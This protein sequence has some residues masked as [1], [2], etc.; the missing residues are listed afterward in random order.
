VVV[1]DEDAVVVAER[2]VVVRVV[3]VVRA[4]DAGEDEE[5]VVAVVD[6]VRTGEKT[7]TANPNRG[8]LR[9]RHAASCIV[10]RVRRCMFYNGGKGMVVYGG[11]GCVG[12][13]PRPTFIVK[14]VYDE[15]MD[16]RLVIFNCLTTNLVFVAIQSRQQPCCS[17]II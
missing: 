1:V 8:L 16:A 7:A 12:H 11:G 9:R 13:P 15:R 2:A 10:R 3:A 6:G 14:Q 4:V 5:G 17:F